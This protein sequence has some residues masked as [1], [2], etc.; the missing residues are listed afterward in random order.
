M[1][2]ALVNITL[3]KEDFGLHSLRSGG[4]TLAANKSVK[5]CL[6]KRH[7][8]WKSDNVKDEYIDDNLESLLVVMIYVLMIAPTFKHT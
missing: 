7:A 5:D 6:F 8:E 1:P 4:A 2:E 3:I